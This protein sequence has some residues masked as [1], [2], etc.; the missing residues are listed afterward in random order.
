MLVSKALQRTELKIRLARILYKIVRLFFRD[1]P[2][3]VR[4]NGIKY[5]LDLSEGIELSIF[6]FGSFQ[7]HVYRN[8]LLDISGQATII[9][10][11]ANIGSMALMF[12]QLFQ[13]AKIH[14]FEPTDYACTKF[15][16]NLELNPKLA[17]RISLVQSFVSAV[18]TPNPDI[19]AYASWKVGGSAE[20]GAKHPVHFGTLKAASGVAAIT[21]DEYCAQNGLADIRL[22]KIDTDGHEFQVLQG[23]A[24]VVRVQHPYV[25]FEVGRYVMDEN[26][27]DFA[28][29]LNY[30][31]QYGYTLHNSS[32]NRLITECNWREIIPQCGTIDVLA[33]PPVR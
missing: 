33:L 23:A 4:R 30:F 7:K 6:L 18:A 13:S 11:G 8:R 3:C 27:I 31:N 5:E 21:I 20:Q 12:A 2:I 24:D 9:D 16:R 10:V 29:Y 25:V 22:I 28:Q 15:R 19:N 26:G 32:N 17:A 14:A 1:S